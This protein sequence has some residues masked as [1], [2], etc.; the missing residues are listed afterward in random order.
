MF[1]FAYILIFL[2]RYIIIHILR[3]N[4]RMLLN[5]KFIR[6]HT[7]MNIKIVQSCI[8][9]FDEIGKNDAIIALSQKNGVGRGDHVFYSPPGGLYIVMRLQGV[10]INPHTLTPAVGLAVHDTVQSL[11][12]MQTSLKWVNDVMYKNKKAAGILCKSPRKAEYLVGVGINYATP[13][14]EL[15]RAKLNDV[16]ISL[17]APESRATGFVTG[18]LTQIRRASIATFDHAR[19]SKL[20]INIGKQVGFIY[21]GVKVQGFADR[22]EADGTLI[23]RIGNAEIA[24]DAGEVSIIREVS[25]NK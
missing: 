19:Y 5:E 16:A 4:T 24:V 9:T 7:G 6:L 13:T 22:I 17:Q 11:L 1:F 3:L 20:C 14:I 25:P 8:S 18:L 15:V 2:H 21:N 10:Y 12:G 23:V